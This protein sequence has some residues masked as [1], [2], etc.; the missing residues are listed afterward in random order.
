MRSATETPYFRDAAM[1]LQSS[2][3]ILA[4][5]LGIGSVAAETRED[6]VAYVLGGVEEGANVDG[7]RYKREANGIFNGSDDS[8]QAV[9]IQVREQRKCV[10]LVDLDIKQDNKDYGK[11]SSTVDLNGVSVKQTSDKAD[12][13]KPNITCNEMKISEGKVVNEKNCQPVWSVPLLTD[14]APDPDR[15]T[16]AITTLATQLCPAKSF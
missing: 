13:S 4:L 6:A 3:L 7:M 10:F 15:M 9:R 14:R 16:K 12:F 2:A 5:I 8:G 11:F 1:R